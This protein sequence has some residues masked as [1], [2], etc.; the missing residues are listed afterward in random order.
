MLL[1]GKAWAAPL[2]HD[3]RRQEL[4]MRR[5]R[6]SLPVAVQGT[7]RLQLYRVH[8]TLCRQLSRRATTAPDVP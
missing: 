7:R 8:T 5:E 1:H 6:V 3:P 4:L 2:A